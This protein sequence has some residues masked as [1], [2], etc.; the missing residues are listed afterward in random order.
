MIADFL[1]VNKIDYEYDKLLSLGSEK[2]RFRPD[3]FLTGKGIIIEYW[4]MEGDNDYDA[5]TK[6]KKTSYMEI[7]QPFISIRR[8]DIR[9]IDYV[10]KT[11]LTRLGVVFD[12]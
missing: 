6:S 9:N 11:K 10:L 2:K 5:R 7:G 1:H 8:E 4:G 12:K 3:F